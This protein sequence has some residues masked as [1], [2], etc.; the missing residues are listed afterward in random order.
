MHR[1][2]LTRRAGATLIELVTGIVIISIALAVLFSLT[3][4]S[5]RRSVDPMI[6]VQAGAVAQSYLEEIM[7]K[8]FCDPD[9]ASDCVAAC[10]G[11]GA[12]GNAACTASEGA[13]A[14]F[15]DVCDYDN[16]TDNPPR[17]VTGN[18]IP[19][20]GRYT[21]T[22]QVVDDASVNLNG[23]SGANGMSVRVDVSVA[24]PAMPDN[25]RISGFRANY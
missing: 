12:C 8:P 3:S 14:L 4:H 22:V 15:D 6:Q 24:H 23:L 1:G 21:V 19:G 13:R 10:T 5:T 7:E 9:L 25:V 18:A 17:D 16:S 2:L 20:L 11:A